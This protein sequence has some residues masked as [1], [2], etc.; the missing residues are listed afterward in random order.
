MNNKAIVNEL[1]AVFKLRYPPIAFFYTD[2]PPYE[3]YKPKGNSPCI[4]QLL[5]GVKSGRPLVLG[6]ISHKLCE[7]GLTN[8]GFQKRL[9]GTTKFLTDVEKF[10]KTIELA[11]NLMESIP[12]RKST[13]EFAVFMQLN[14]VNIDLYKPLLVIFF[15][16][17]SQLTGLTQLANFD[18]VNK[19]KLGR[20][21]NCQTIITEPLLELDSNQTPRAIIG[22]MS[23][24]STRMFIKQDE[25]TITVSYDRLLSM[26]KNINKSFLSLDHWKRIYDK[27]Q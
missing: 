25:A 18:T 27:I 7:G 6:K 13:A 14:Q 2:N 23:D 9:E 20:G 3:T 16:N 22:C 11:D 15:A 10:V 24:T 5:N 4:L 12:F 19:T 1:T 8:L 26:V 21:V 17:I